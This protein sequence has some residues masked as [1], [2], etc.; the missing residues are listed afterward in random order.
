MRKSFKQITAS[1]VAIAILTF[2]VGT[3]STFAAVGN[4]GPG[5]R[6]GD[7]TEAYPAQDS[8]MQSP[9]STSYTPCWTNG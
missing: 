4:G 1:A 2:A 5:A 7:A 8:C 9:A 6:G 3:T